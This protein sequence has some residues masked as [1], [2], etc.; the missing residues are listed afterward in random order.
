ML[1]R[2]TKLQVIV[3]EIE[4]LKQMVAQ[5]EDKVRECKKAWL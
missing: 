1:K 5:L 2:E 3:V 4:S